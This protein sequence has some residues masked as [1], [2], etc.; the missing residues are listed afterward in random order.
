MAM[1]RVAVYTLAKLRSVSLHLLRSPLPRNGFASLRSP[2][3]LEIPLSR[4][5]GGLIRG[6][7]TLGLLS[8]EMT[9]IIRFY[10]IMNIICIL[11]FIIY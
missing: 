10:L 2:R 3:F 8:R 9:F 7:R 5:K 4:L 1:P 11:I 6:Y